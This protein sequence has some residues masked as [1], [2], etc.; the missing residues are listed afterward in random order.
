MQQGNT[1]ASIR[2]VLNG[3]NDCR[4]AILEAPEVDDTVLSLV[5]ATTMSRG[6]L[7]LVIATT[8]FLDRAQQGFFWLGPSGQVSKVTYRGTTPAG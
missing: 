6:Y 1:S 2:I 3:S 8:G 7:S 5:P 4:D